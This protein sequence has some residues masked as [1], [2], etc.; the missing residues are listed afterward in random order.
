[1]KNRKKIKEWLEGLGHTVIYIKQPGVN[2]VGNKIRDILFNENTTPNKHTMRA[3]FLADYCELIET[4]YRRKTNKDAVVICDRYVPVSN[5]VY[6]YFGDEID[7]KELS[8]LN[9][10]GNRGLFFP[11]LIMIYSIKEE[12]MIDRLT[13]RQGLDGD[14]N[15]YD[16]KSIDF[17]RNIRKGYEQ[18]CRYLHPL[19]SLVT[20]YIDAEK[21]IDEVSNATKQKILEYFEV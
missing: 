18:V 2:E 5:M 11:D 7:F 13:K 14:I 9:S 3:L 12:T 4:V 16:R 17:K 10:F 8:M 15:Y 21:T 6:G 20:H 19:E 1:L